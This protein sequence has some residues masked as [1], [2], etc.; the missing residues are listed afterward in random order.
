METASPRSFG[1]TKKIQEVC[2]Q[3][4]GRAHTL[5]PGAKLPTVIEMRDEL[6]VSMATLDAALRELEEQNILTRR[7]GIGVFVSSELHTTAIALVCDSSFL[8]AAGH[9]PFW[10]LLL[11]AAQHRARAGGER[12]ELH[13]AASGGDLGAP[14]QRGLT[15][16]I[17]D[18]ALDGVIG[19]GL[20]EDAVRWI[21]AQGVPFV[22]IF[23]PVFGARSASVNFDKARFLALGAAQL[24]ARG[25][26]RVALWQVEPV[27]CDEGCLLGQAEEARL[28]ERLARKHGM[29]VAPPIQLA[30]ESAASLSRHEQGVALA[31]QFAAPRAGWP[32]GVLISDDML[33]HAALMHLRQLGVRV[34]E[35]A[36]I[37]T[38]ANAGSRVLEGHGVPLTLLEYHPTETVEAAF[39]ALEALLRTGQPVA[40]VFPEPRVRVVVG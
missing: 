20:Y 15:R 2:A 13:L 21:E 12:F 32:D 22:S 35:D 1:R 34:G 36:Q 10:E 38:H 37:V 16:D 9:S 27:G 25:S 11:E 30:G 28:F 8:R 33:T 3:L 5:G 18:R 4:L 17:K 39:G 24:A 31:G 7:H 19:V 26:K 6:G 23:G 14:L 29:T 40:N